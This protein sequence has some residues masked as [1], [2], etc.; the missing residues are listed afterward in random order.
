MGGAI[1]ILALVWLSLAVLYWVVSRCLDQLF[2]L[3][4]FTLSRSAIFTELFHA[5]S[6]DCFHGVVS[7]CLD[8]LFLFSCFTL[9]R[10]AVFTELF[11]AVSIDCFHWVVSRCLHLPYSLFHAVSIDCFHYVVSPTVF[12]DVSVTNR[13]IHSTHWSRQLFIIHCHESGDLWTAVVAV[14]K[15]EV[16]TLLCWQHACVCTLV[17][18]PVTRSTLGCNILTDCTQTASLIPQINHSAGSTSAD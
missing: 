18:Y 7:C 16:R 15:L 1:L 12:T 2:S 6:I 10:W 13:K 4:C 9:S 11:H 17:C 5:V 3:S 14:G 8:Q